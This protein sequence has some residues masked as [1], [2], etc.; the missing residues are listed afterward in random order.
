MT[1]FVW[2]SWAIGVIVL[3]YLIFPLIQKY[4]RS[5]PNALGLFVISVILAKGW[6]FFV[7]N[8][9]ESM[10][11][12][13]NEQVSYAWRFGFLQHMP[14][15]LCGIV[16][17]HLFFDYLV[18]MNINTQQK[19][20]LFLIIF[21]IL[22]YAFLLTGKMQSML[23][24]LNILHGICFSL[25]VLGV[26][27]NPFIFLVNKKTAY[28]G[29]ASYSMYLFHPLL[30]FSIIPIYRWSYSFLFN[31]MLGYLASLIVTLIPLII[32]S[33]ISYKFIERK[34]MSLGEK[35]INSA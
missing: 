20:G 35:I 3:M 2:A 16:T 4:S 1:G 10:W 23:W 12:L 27:L 33:L 26:G 9:S 8:Y 25:L 7:I 21:S 22:F 31:D 28:W 29:K 34:G 13:K 30:I 15:F 19:T 17:Y 32:I 11:M 6:S 14:V 18:K 5:L 24:G